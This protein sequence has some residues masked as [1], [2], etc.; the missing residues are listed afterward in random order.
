LLQLHGQRL[1]LSQQ[2]L[3]LHQ[4]ELRARTDLETSLEDPKGLL[5]DREPSTKTLRHS[6]IPTGSPLCEAHPP[7]NRSKSAPAAADQAAP[8]TRNRREAV[9]GPAH[10]KFE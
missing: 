6:T 2:R 8:S 5:R 3:N 4:L 1:R 9:R 10:T 7:G